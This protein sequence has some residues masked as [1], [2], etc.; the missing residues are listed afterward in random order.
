MSD[1][2]KK[3]ILLLA[4][5]RVDLA[6]Q[7]IDK[8]RSYKPVRLYISID[9]PSMNTLEDFQEIN[10]VRN[11]LM[12]AVDW[13]C[14]IH[15]RFLETNHGCRLAVS[16][17]INWFFENEEEGIILEEDC[18]PSFDFFTFCSDLLDAYRDDPRIGVIAGVNFQDGKIRGS[19]SQ[20][21]FSKYAHC[22]GWATWRSAWK[23]FDLEISFWPSYKKSREWKE[24]NLFNAKEIKYWNSIFDKV[25]RGGFDS[26]AYPWL[27]CCWK[28]R[29]ITAIPNANLV[30][31]VG[32]DSRATHTRDSS[33]KFAHQKH[34]T[35]VDD[36]ETNDLI[37]ID[38]AADIYTFENVYYIHAPRLTTFI[39]TLPKKL[40]E[41]IKGIVNN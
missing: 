2:K 10:L 25:F 8:I 33:F 36:M 35:L 13:D 7:V 11:S 5:K 19:N 37:Q 3:P 31:N 15:T 32:F 28:H 21:Y 23:K 29:M 1:I 17:G 16:S 38:Q 26:W 27:L 30:T 39:R 9:G 24:L 18:L 20:Y 41:K 12:T 6:L 40:L 34:G 22:W 4:W 14:E